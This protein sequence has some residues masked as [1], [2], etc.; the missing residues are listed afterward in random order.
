M[1]KSKTKQDTFYLVREDAMPD[2]LMKVMRVKDI[3]DQNHDRSVNSVVR[4]VGI[5]RSAYY[6]YRRSVRPVRTMDSA[7]V[8]TLLI[9]MEALDRSPSRCLDLVYE[10][11]A[12]IISFQQSPPTDGLFHLLLTIDT[13]PLAEP[14]DELVRRLSLARGV[15][16][17]DVLTT[18]THR[19]ET[20]PFFKK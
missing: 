5:S 9:V 19:K 10:S 6:K 12:S 16:G 17:V 11:G 1:A 18:M 7:A 20:S 14:I 3:L 4:E 2:V 13:A 15:V 8:M